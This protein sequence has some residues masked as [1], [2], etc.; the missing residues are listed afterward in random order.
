MTLATANELPLWQKD[1][2]FP[3]LGHAAAEWI[4]AN[5]C[6]G[7]GD[8]RGEPITIT[9]DLYRFYCRAL[10]IHPRAI[11]SDPECECEEMQ[12]RFVRKINVLSRLKGYAKTEDIAWILHWKLSGACQFGGWLENDEIKPVV[13]RSPYIPVAATSEDQAEDTL[14]GCFVAIASEAKGTTH[15]RVTDR[16]VTN[17]VNQGEAKMV[18]SS[19]ARNDGGKPSAIGLDEAHLMYGNELLSLGKTLERNLA[20]RAIADPQVFIATTMF[21]VGQDSYAELLWNR[22]D[23]DSNILYDHH[24]AS[25]AWDTED[26]TQLRAAIKEAAGDAL[27]WLNVRQMMSSYRADPSEG[28][29]YWLNRYGGGG[30]AKLINIKAFRDCPRATPLTSSDLI[31]VG[32]DGS[33]FND[34]SGIVAVRLSDLSLHYIWSMRP[35]GTESGAR[36][37]QTEMD[38]TVINLME[39][40]RITRIYVDP[41]YITDYIARWSNAALRSKQRG[42]KPQVVSWYTNRYT[43]MANATR[44]LASAVNL[45]MQPHDHHPTMM[46]HFSNAYKKEVSATIETDGVLMPGF[47]PRKV[48]PKSNDKIDL[49]VCAILARQAATDSLAAGEDKKVRGAAHV[50]G[51]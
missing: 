39:N 28:E 51:L 1:R 23:T 35:D 26:D 34:M 15:L 50:I 14:W 38:H 11:C 45:E 41:P 9:D 32:I 18:T 46:E 3:T 12:G 30:N 24:Q 48:A 29:R 31:C 16:R 19:S 7:P 17:P 10:I 36:E 37:M 6:H 20:K 44:E 33:Q 2:P 22:A 42:M 47:I 4:E 25:D 5:L 49:V 43:A 27:G 8:V 21:M 40:F 13:C